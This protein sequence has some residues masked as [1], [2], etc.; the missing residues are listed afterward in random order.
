MRFFGRFPENEGKALSKTLTLIE[1]KE[2]LIYNKVI[3]LLYMEILT[4][5][6][7]IG[8]SIM[9]TIPKTI[10]EQEGIKE[11]QLI[12]IEVKKAKKSG[13]GIFKGI[14]PFKREDKFKGQL[15]E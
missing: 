10:V 9:V 12:K 15:E 8:G 14:G 2:N 1:K 11:N 5:T 13:F 4:K 6:R 7:K 3:L